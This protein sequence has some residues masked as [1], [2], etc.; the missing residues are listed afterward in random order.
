M[1]K[2]ILNEIFKNV[3][4]VL[5]VVIAGNDGIPVET[6]EKESIPL[7]SEVVTAEM[8][9]I[10]RSV[11]DFLNATQGGAPEEVVIKTERYII[12][13][14]VINEDYFAL[15]LLDYRGNLGKSRYLLRRAVDRLQKE[16]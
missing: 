4:G 6:V 8:T 16:F 9:N 3:E 12:V 10:I 14:R 7:G 15:V 5:S 11:S 1:F 13:V 2:E